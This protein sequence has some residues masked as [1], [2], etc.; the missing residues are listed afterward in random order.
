MWGNVFKYLSC[1]SLGVLGGNMGDDLGA[2]WGVQW[3]FETGYVAK[4][5]V[6]LSSGWSTWQRSWGR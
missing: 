2:P 4:I 1:Y 5:T 3:W 6:F